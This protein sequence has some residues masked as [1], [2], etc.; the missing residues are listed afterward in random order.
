MKI[1][2]HNYEE[3][4]ILYW[5]NEL[6]EAQKKEVDIFVDQH[7]DLQDEFRLF[8]ETRF[9][10]DENISLKE[11]DFLLNVDQTFINS[12][13][14][15]D[16]LLSY[17][18]NELTV[19]QKTEVEKY[20]LNHPAVQQEFTIFQKTKLQPES[21]IILPDKS[22]LYRREEKV[23]VIKMTW[24]RV[25]VAAALILI[26]GLV[27]F[28]II[29]TDNKDGKP[30]IVKQS[31]PANNNKTED[32]TLNQ[33]TKQEKEISQP[34]K[35]E[36]KKTKTTI[37][38]TPVIQ[39]TVAVLN[40]NNKNN[41]PKE[42]RVNEQ[43]LIAQNTVPTVID[44]PVIIEPRKTINDAVVI[45]DADKKN[46]VLE[47][48]IVTERPSPSY[49][50][51][52]PSVDQKENADKGGLKGFLRKATRVFEHRTKMQTTTDDNKLLVGMFA[53]SLK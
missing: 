30:L 34:A 50:V 11:K 45:A 5:D 51:Y 41:L 36:N 27:T 20:I 6:T 10:P 28:R 1:D 17:I 40:P 31:L 22:I 33:N 53:V 26:A 16:H 14:Y 32:L 29:N 15:T 7:K 19:N 23:S 18:D 48:T 21:E 42:K 47:K 2:R 37:L 24:F 52:N 3:F 49:T 4:F 13:N 12:S 9:K 38:K 39:N 25:A 44:Q 35:I 46:E 43:Q 8:G